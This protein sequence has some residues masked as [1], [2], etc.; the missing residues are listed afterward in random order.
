MARAKRVP[1]SLTVAVLAFSGMAASL[2]FT[3]TIPLLHAMPDLL[4]VSPN[5]AS[6][7]I[8]ITLLASAI[9]TPIL[10]RMA[11]M[12]GKRRMIVV[13]LAA[14]TI[15]SF[16]VAVGE[17]YPTMIVGRGLQGFAQ[18]L[19]PIGISLL[20]DLLP[21]ERV[22]SAVALMS[23]TLGIGAAV[24]MTLS[25][26][27]YEWFGWESVFW[28]SGLAGLTFIIGVLLA[29]D[30]SPVRAPA[31]FDIAGAV[32]LSV[33]L[34][35]TLVVISKVGSWEITVIAALIGVALVGIAGWVPLELRVS[36]PMVDLRT[37]VKRP[38]LLAN[39]S[40]L[41]A[42]GAFMV[43]MLVTTQAVQAPHGT[44]YGFGLS[45]VGAGLVMLPGG[46]VVVAIAPLT[47][48]LMNRW[49]GRRVLVAGNIVLAL[50]YVFRVLFA[51]SLFTVVAGTMLIGVGTAM[52]FA[53]LPTILMGAVPL[54]ET[55]AANGI[56][57][58]VRSLAM[59]ICSGFLAL[60]ATTMSVSLDGHQ[61]LSA[62]AIQLCFWLASACGLIGAAIAGFIPADTRR[63]L[64]TAAQNGR[65]QALIRGRIILGDDVVPRHPAIVTFM[66]LDGT[67]VDWSRADLNGRYSAA[68][69]G[70]GRYLA[71]ANAVG[72]APQTYVIDVADAETEWDA[73]ISEQL[74]L[75]G[76]VTRPT[77][78][79]DGI[80]VV[81]YRAE[82][83]FV[84][85]VRCD[86]GGRYRMQLPPTGPYVLTAIDP[87]EAWA[88]SQKIHVGVQS[89]SVEIVATT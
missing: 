72:W 81:L 60:L 82:G 30:E 23:G 27:L 59:S 64:E 15:G 61:F 11:D 31:R 32:L 22:G 65:E 73:A 88:H 54:T 70:A 25:G 48:A 12:Y 21:R 53:A 7:I 2:Q 3:L 57:A 5:D 34:T 8:T 14:M 45:V 38:V 66:N 44:G 19:I 78:S 40:T 6:W 49:G 71:V 9:A 41:F 18:S 33:I 63:R 26:A 58:L 55:A 79:V 75:S 62:P 39:L 50:A 84:S 16:V 37:A 86:E 20:R 43:N 80:I 36:N 35:A 76:Y 24:G 42:T 89:T 47:G 69:R 77:G 1:V 4:D 29:V 74:S 28:F 87:D 67:P 52:T 85:S 68:L 56:N 83:H 10:S 46:L 17:S 51:D 13:A